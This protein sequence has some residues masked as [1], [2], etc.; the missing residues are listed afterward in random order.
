[1]F[2]KFAEFLVRIIFFKRFRQ[3][4]KI[5]KAVEVAGRGQTTDALIR[6]KEIEPKLHPAL[7]SIFSLTKGRILMSADRFDEAERSL[8]AALAA[9]PTNEKIKLDLA[10]VTGR[11]LLFD[12]ARKHL[13]GLEASNEDSVKERALELLDLIDKIT[14]GKKEAEY[15]ERAKVFSSKKIGSSRE[16]AGLPANLE[17]LDNW[18]SSD[19]ELARESADE[20]A[21]LIGYSILRKDGTTT[22]LGL[23]IEDFAVLKTD[24]TVLKPFEIVAKRFASD[25]TKLVDLID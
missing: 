11:L 4:D 6:L 17:L 8:E 22:Q 12:D 13:A 23:S 14:S 10:M 16:V 3:A 20:I 9:D 19:K 24:G 15:E 5:G 18:I 1:M 7:T 25:D 2:W 21:L